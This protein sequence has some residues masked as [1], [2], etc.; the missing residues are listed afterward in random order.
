MGVGTAGGL[1]HLTLYIVISYM[2]QIRLKPMN[3]IRYF[4]KYS[5]IHQGGYKDEAGTN[6]EQHTTGTTE[7]KCNL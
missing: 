1:V 3:F 6:V 4:E 5:F 7:T 2:N